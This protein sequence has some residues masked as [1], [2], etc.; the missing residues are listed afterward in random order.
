MERDKIFHELVGYLFS[1]Y[2]TYEPDVITF[3]VQ[4][5]AHVEIG[6]IVCIEHPTLEGVPVFYQV[7]RVPVRRKAKS[8]EE[9]LLRLGKIIKDSSRNYP[10]AVAKQIGYYTKLENLGKRDELRM[11]LQHV[12]PQS[13]VYKPSE[14]ILELLLRPEEDYI[15]LGEIYPSFKQEMSLELPL[16]MRQGLLVVGGVGTGKTTTMATVIYNI[17]KVLLNKGSQ[18]HLLIIDKDGE[19]GSQK[20]VSLVGEENYRRIHIDEISLG[21]QIFRSPDDFRKRLFGV[22]GIAPNSKEARAINVAVESAVRDGVEL[23][24]EP[25]FV[26]EKIIPRL[27]SPEMRESVRNALYNWKKSFKAKEEG[28]TTDDVALLLKKISIVHIDLSKTRDWANVFEKLAIILKLIYDE[29]IYDE[30]FGVIIVLDEAHLFVPERGGI[31]LTSRE[32]VE[33]L[34][35]I[36]KLIATTGPR[37]GVT[38]FF[39]TQRPALVDKTI[40][41]QLGQNIIAHRVEDV[42]LARLT[43]ILGDIAKEV[44]LLPRGWALVKSSASK[45]NQSF[46]VKIKATDMPISVGK[47]AYYRFKEKPLQILISKGGGKRE[48]KTK[49]E[50]KELKSL[51]TFL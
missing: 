32:K 35:D 38:P 19:Y 17:M 20:L 50:K 51:D 4:L 22:L 46:I 18:P 15:V 26:E 28:I 3:T 47:T 7:I 24:F 31:E 37:N 40:T 30:N 1:E 42:D 11:L 2:G 41:T 44:S 5:N 27:T 10:R 49:N 29:A 39:A 36:I 12:I 45:I 34:K 23:R 16:L 13:P 33:M 6:E 9:D 8:F 21:S 25:D 48:E 14:E 43:E